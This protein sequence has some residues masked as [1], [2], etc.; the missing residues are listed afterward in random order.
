MSTPVLK[1]S[2]AAFR[3]NIAAVRE[4]L[5]ASQLMLVMKDDA[6]GHGRPSRSARVRCV[7]RRD[8]GSVK[9]SSRA[10]PMAPPASRRAASSL[11]W[12]A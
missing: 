3:A 7:R 4:R 11:Y 5:G 6:Y 2:R 10:V 12:Y 9:R 1:I 8:A